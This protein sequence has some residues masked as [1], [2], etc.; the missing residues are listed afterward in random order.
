MNG[1]HRQRLSGPDWRLK[2][3]VGEDWLSRGAF[4]PGTRDTRHWRPAT[5]PG[6]VQHD[7]WQAGEIPNPYVGRNSLLCE[8]VPQRTWVYRK[9]FRVDE[10]LRGRQLR[11]RFEGVDYAAQFYL[12]GERLGA[13]EGLF[14]TVVFDVTEK[15]LFGAENLIAVVIAPAP[16]E[17]PQV[18]Y[19]SRVRTFKPRM[20]YGWDFCPRMVH[21]GV[22]DD[23]WLE[24]TGP[25]RVEAL[26]VRPHLSEAHSRADVEVNAT[27]WAAAPVRAQVSTSISVGGEVVASHSAWVDLHPGENSA[28]VSLALTEPRLWWPN[29]FGEQPLYEAEVRVDTPD[30]TWDART[31][32]FGLRSLAFQPNSPTHPGAQPY[33]LVVNGRPIY[34]MGWNWVPIDALYG[35]E[36]HDKLR[37]LLDLAQRAH[38]N[39]LRVWGG[40]LIEKEAF[41]AECDR[42]GLLVWQEFIQSSSGVDNMPSETPAFVEKLASFARA[43]IPRRRNHPSLALWCG[44]NELQ[45]EAPLDERHPALRALHAVVRDFDPDRLWLPTSPTGPVFMNSL[46]N[47]DKD[48]HSLHEVHG[49]WEHQGLEAQYTLYN[50]TT[51]LLHSE[52]GAE[53][54]TNTR[55]LAYVLPKGQ[56]PVS[57]DNPNWQHLGAYWVWEARWREMLGDWDDV[58]EVRRATQFLQ[59]EAVRY[60][61]EANRRRK[62]QNSGTLPWQFNEPYP[63]AACTSAVDYFGEAKPLYY[64]VRRA[65]APLTVT[66]RFARM[67]WPGAG[68]FEAALFANYSGLEPLTDAALT[69]EVCDA[70]GQVIARLTDTVTIAPNAVT[71]LGGLRAGLGSL[72]GEVFVLDVVLRSGEAAAA[73]RYLF[74]RTATIRPLLDLESTILEAVAA[75]HGDCWSVTLRN[76]GRVLASCIWLQDPRPHPAPG[77]VVFDDNH[78]SLFPGET[79]TVAVEWDNVPAGERSL[80]LAGWNT[81]TVSISP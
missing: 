58:D 13:H 48:S 79:R 53:G 44:G 30:G 57:L 43:V 26:H 11:L 69:A 72:A 3:Y 19:T 33:T 29:G 60:A 71:P 10:A 75:R 5:V 20:N 76:T 35:V 39:M 74:S 2:D 54:L 25:A 4:H 24:V 51:S 7:L 28:S 23:V 50:R 31:A 55:A 21:L 62:W 42:R 38:V 67:A 46:E 52:F 68:E 70:R 18:G 12:N 78:F 56:L 17:Q 47:L 34:I 32:T 64:A 36:R 6:S 15:A 80:R 81:P 61:A 66:A 27:L 37:H 9:S 65:Y 22:W 41:Y 14:E 16:D 45:G 73:N 40:G 59:A 1:P 77:Y 63:M 8:W 49:P